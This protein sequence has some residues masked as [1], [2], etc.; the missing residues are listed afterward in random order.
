LNIPAVACSWISRS[1]LCE[2]DSTTGWFWLS[3]MSLP[4]CSAF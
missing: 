2:N 1:M 4:V 3:S